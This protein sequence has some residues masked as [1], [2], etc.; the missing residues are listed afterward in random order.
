MNP[1][2]PEVSWNRTKYKPIELTIQVFSMGKGEATW[3]N[4]LN[5][6]RRH[7][8]LELSFCQSATG[9]A[10][11][12]LILFQN[13]ALWKNLDWSFVWQGY[14]QSFNLHL[15]VAWDSSGRIGRDLG[16]NLD[17]DAWLKPFR[18]RWWTW[19][20][21]STFSGV[22]SLK[23]VF[24]MFNLSISI[25]GLLLLK[26]ALMFHTVS[27]QFGESLLEHQ[28][29]GAVLFLHPFDRYFKLL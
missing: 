23:T 5:F 10:R 28:M 8:G 26:D 6:E 12:L 4:R 3:V 27:E 7:A 16:F 14:V 17:H 22:W 11:Q 13:L 2:C 9:R 19:R 15:K 1:S 21:T 29:W 18:R 25:L 24:I 20:F